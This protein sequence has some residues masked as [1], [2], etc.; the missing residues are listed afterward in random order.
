MRKRHDYFEPGDRI[1]DAID[2]V[3]SVKRSFVGDTNEARSLILAL[4]DQADMSI[5][6]QI[7]VAALLRVPTTALPPVLKRAASSDAAEHSRTNVK[8]SKDS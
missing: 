5:D 7:A 4:C 3:T 1:S 8:T 2:A 6:A